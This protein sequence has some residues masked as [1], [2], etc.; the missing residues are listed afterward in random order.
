[1]AGPRR[2]RGGDCVADLGGVA[3]GGGTSAQQRAVEKEQRDAWA[4]VRSR[5]WP[6]WLSTAPATALHSGGAENRGNRLEEGDKDL[7]AISKLS[8]TKL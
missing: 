3:K 5:T 8:G 2:R 7:N 4:P 6:G 1:M